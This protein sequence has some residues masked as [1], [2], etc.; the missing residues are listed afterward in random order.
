MP[1]NLETSALKF[2][3]RD[4]EALILTEL[5]KHESNTV[6]YLCVTNLSYARDEGTKLTL[7]SNSHALRSNILYLLHIIVSP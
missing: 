6:T 2:D 1:E 3:R 5:H 7:N 4:A